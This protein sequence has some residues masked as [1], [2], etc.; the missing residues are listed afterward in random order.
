MHPLGMES[1][2]MLRRRGCSIP[3]RSVVCVGRSLET[4]LP[5]KPPC[6]AMLPVKGS[7]AAWEL[8]KSLSWCLPGMIHPSHGFYTEKLFLPFI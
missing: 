7:L 4:D 3:V 1:A 6:P 5:L 8:H 2:P